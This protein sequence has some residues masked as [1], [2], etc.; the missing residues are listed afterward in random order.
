VRIG[1]AV[2]RVGTARTPDAGSALW[3]SLAKEAVMDPRRRYGWRDEDIEA[4]RREEWQRER[5]RQRLRMRSDDDPR[6]YDLEWS[7]ERGSGYDEY[8][9]RFGPADMPARYRPR[10]HQSRSA[11]MWPVEPENVAPRRQF[12]EPRSE[13][14]REERR[15]AGD[16]T[17]RGPRG[18]K[19]SDERILDDIHDVL[20]RHPQI[21]AT[22]V[23]VKVADCAVT[24]RG[25]VPTRPQKWLAEEVA[26]DVYGV[27]E[28]KNELRV[29]KG[30][31]HDAAVYGATAYAVGVSYGA[32]P[33]V[34]SPLG[35]VDVREGMEV[36]GSDLKRI[37]AV[38]EVR[39]DDFFIDRPRAVDLFVPF[40]A[41]RSL[42]D[43]QIVLD[44]PAERIDTIAW[45]KAMESTGRASGVPTQSRPE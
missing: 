32:T 30:A 33:G 29:E 26:A 6:R 18:Y 19:R 37:G 10:E 4:R 38:K 31:G 25:C 9:A 15:N 20:T 43:G 41:V 42:R 21:D 34:V 44:V 2:W 8:G 39:R 35:R 40:S 5:E 22:D 11:W 24:L 3:S 45:T 28:V 7:D 12:D 36:L 1:M 23:E 13:A 17:G 14:L 27:N 16:F